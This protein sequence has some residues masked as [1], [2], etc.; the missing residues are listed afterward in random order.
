MYL[1]R[2]LAPGF[3]EKKRK[4]QDRKL[5][6]KETLFY[7]GK[8]MW[9]KW[10]PC[11]STWLSFFYLPSVFSIGGNFI[12]GRIK[13]NI[14]IIYILD[15]ENKIYVDEHLFYKTDTF[16]VLIKRKSNWFIED[17]MLLLLS[18]NGITFNYKNCNASI[19]VFPNYSMLMRIC[20][21]PVS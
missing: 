19:C 6:E 2:N 9:V 20:F 17:L 14:V 13:F 18:E 8:A 7:T 15:F 11:P 12:H 5:K 21:C 1:W 16:E 3:G 4:K 10:T